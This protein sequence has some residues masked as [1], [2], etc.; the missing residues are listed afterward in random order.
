MKIQKFAEVAIGS[1]FKFRGQTFL[2]L[3]PNL[4][5]APDGF[6]TIFHGEAMVEPLPNGERSPLATGDPS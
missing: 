1:R 3:S 6:H 2:K 5:E 4:A